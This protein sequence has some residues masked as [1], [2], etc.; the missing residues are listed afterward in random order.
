MDSLACTWRQTARA[1]VRKRSH[2]HALAGFIVSPASPANDAY[3]VGV[4]HPWVGGVSQGYRRLRLEEFVLTDSGACTSRLTAGGPVCPRR[5]WGWFWS[6]RQRP[7][8]VPGAATPPRDARCRAPSLLKPDFDFA[9][10]GIFGFHLAYSG[11][12]SRRGHDAQTRVSDVPHAPRRDVRART[13]RGIAAPQPVE[14]YFSSRTR[15]YP[16]LSRWVSWSRLG[17][18]IRSV[19]HVCRLCRSLDRPTSP[20]SC[21]CCAIMGAM[22]ESFRKGRWRALTPCTHITQ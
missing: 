1:P 20:P 9:S 22:E 10:N 4:R 13:R 8:A 12:V 17:L 5:V 7:G 2:I 15:R 19:L 21:A 11:P 16:R 6:S 18:G 3:R 14:K